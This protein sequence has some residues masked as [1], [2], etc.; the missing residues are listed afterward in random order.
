[1]S[2]TPPKYWNYFLLATPSESGEEHIIDLYSGT[3]EQA[4]NYLTPRYPYLNPDSHV[5]PAIS[6]LGRVNV[7]TYQLA[8]DPQRIPSTGELYDRAVLVRFGANVDYPQIAG[9]RTRRRNRRHRK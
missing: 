8:E 1:M 2:N 9:R 3:E 5:I 7:F 4:L 6:S